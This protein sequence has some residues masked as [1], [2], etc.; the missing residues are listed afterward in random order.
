MNNCALDFKVSG[1]GVVPAGEYRSISCSGSARISG[2]VRCQ[3]LSVAGSA[4]ADGAIDC[5]GA[6][7]VSGSFRGMGVRADLLSASGSCRLEG[8]VQAK[9]VKCSGSCKVS[10]AVTAE[11]VHLSGSAAIDGLLNAERIELVI[12][13]S[14][15]GSVGG[16][17]IRVRGGKNC[18][19]FGWF[20]RAKTTLVTDSIEGD[21]V[22]LA[23]VVAK[24]VRTTDAVIGENC[25][26][27]VLE[28]SGNA[29]ISP[30]AE[31][32]QVVRTN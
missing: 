27:D 7:K 9:T 19:L 13:E 8:D 31:V 24:V 14:R 26:I 20:N 4:R 17:E 23:G 29:E 12:E 32:K 16:A 22:E 11:E 5:T 3:S 25:R 2:D 6:V 15:I 28:Y 18:G 1:S 30:S 10:G 21:R